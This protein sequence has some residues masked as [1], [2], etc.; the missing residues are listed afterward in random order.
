MVR[1]KKRYTLYGISLAKCQAQKSNE[2]IWEL[3]DLSTKTVHD[4]IWRFAGDNAPT[5]DGN[6][7]ARMVFA[8]TGVESPVVSVEPAAVSVEPAAASATTPAPNPPVE[9]CKSQ[10]CIMC[11]Q[12]IANCL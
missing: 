3:A 11:H 2:G 4:F 9:G 10:Q 1:F 8:D 5:A 12:L 7:G 6:E